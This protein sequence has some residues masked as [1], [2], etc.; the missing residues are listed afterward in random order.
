MVS[1]GRVHPFR[2]F[3]L[4]SVSAPTTAPPKPPSH[5]VPQRTVPTKPVPRP[6]PEPT[7]KKA[8]II[9]PGPKRGPQAYRHVR[10]KVA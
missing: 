3:R 9:I 5:P 7:P 2:R 1:T 4:R 6:R 8:P 10:R